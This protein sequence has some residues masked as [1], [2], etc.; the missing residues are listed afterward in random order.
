M[1]I[2]HSSREVT[3]KVVYYG[4]GL[5]GKTS[6]LQ[7]LFSVTNPKSRGE[8]ISIETEIERT[9]FFDLLPMNVGLINGYQTKFQLY[10]VPGQVFYDSTRKLV[11]KGADGIVFVADSQELMKQANIE[12]FENLKLNMAN[13]KLSLSEIPLVLQYNKRD[14]SNISAIEELNSFLNKTGELFFPAVATQG[15]GVLET[16]RG[17]STLIIKRIRIMLEPPAKRAVESSYLPVDFS[18]NKKHKIIDREHLPLK[19][20]HTDNLESAAQ[21]ITPSHEYLDPS[22]VKIFDDSPSHYG[23]EDLQIE[24]LSESNGYEHMDDIFD[25]EGQ[26]NDEPE[27]IQDLGEIN[28][29]NEI[30]DDPRPQDFPEN[31]EPQHDPKIAFQPLEIDAGDDTN[32]IRA[33][34]GLD[35]TASD[36]FQN[37]IEEIPGLEDIRFEDDFVI[38][39][40]EPQAAAPSPTRPPSPKEFTGIVSQPCP[41]VKNTTPTPDVD[42]LKEFEVSVKKNEKDSKKPGERKSADPGEKIKEIEELKQS[43]KRDNAP[44]KDKA[45]SP[46]GH[47]GL[48]IFERLKDKTRVTVIRNLP[49]T[50]SSFYIEIKDK[51][52]NLLDT[53]KV[54]ITRETKK[55]TIILDVKK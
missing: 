22:E 29:E 11:L 38:E 6:N 13:N 23:E 47:S 26:Y 34:N 51:E 28:L 52:L 42:R 9:L 20:I 19:K 3:A 35:D 27:E 15:K 24:T 37:D 2:N 36:A 21:K 1:F 5:S 45:D 44:K 7:Y 40:Q 32:E 55:V 41:T 25:Y 33:K 16:L 4:P 14:L 43:I 50:D 49:I 17:I 8:L 31:D 12:S 53:V 10:T 48:D 30:I 46:A 54:D 18:V 39:I